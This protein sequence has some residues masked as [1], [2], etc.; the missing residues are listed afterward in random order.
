MVHVH[1]VDPGF[2]YARLRLDV[3][4]FARVPLW[5]VL[6]LVEELAAVLPV[7][8]G[9]DFADGRAFTLGE[10]GEIALAAGL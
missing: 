6:E 1:P 7:V 4:H 5:V 3:R 8:E 9:E 10:E 2:D